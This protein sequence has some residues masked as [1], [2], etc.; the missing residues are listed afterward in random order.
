MQNIL[1]GAAAGHVLYWYVISDD[2]QFL[3]GDF[4]GLSAYG[5]AGLSAGLSAIPYVIGGAVAGHYILK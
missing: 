1:I 3:K 5:Q 4:T 2:K